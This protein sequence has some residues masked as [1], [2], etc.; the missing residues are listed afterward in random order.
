MFQEELGDL[1]PGFVNSRCG[2]MRRRLF[3]ELDNELT[4]VG[5]EH[6]YSVGN[7]T[8]IQG[9]FFRHHR[10][11]LDDGFDAA[12][13]GQIRNQSALA[14]SLTQSMAARGHSAAQIPH[15]LQ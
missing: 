4:Q 8:L 7:Q 9:D 11:A 14:Y 15:P 5:F 3:R 1:L 6:L 12:F 2:N 13:Q 10:F